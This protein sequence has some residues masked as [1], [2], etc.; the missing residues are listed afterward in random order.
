MPGT[1]GS[2]PISIEKYDTVGFGSIAQ[3]HT[4]M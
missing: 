4:M 2:R 1:A 3:L